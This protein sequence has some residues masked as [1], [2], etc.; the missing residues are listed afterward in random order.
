MFPNTVILFLHEG[1]LLKLVFTC[2]LKLPEPCG[3]EMHLGTDVTPTFSIRSAGY[4]S[5]L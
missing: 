1:V 4:N 3:N 2:S 5:K